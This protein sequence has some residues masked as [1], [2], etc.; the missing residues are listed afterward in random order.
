MAASRQATRFDPRSAAR[1]LLEALREGEPISALPEGAVPQTATQGWRVA[2]AVLAELDLPV[3]GFRAL[4]DGLAGPLL[5]PRLVAAGVQVPLAALPG[6]QASAACLVPLARALPPLSEPYS[7][8]RILAA[9]GPARAAIDLAAWRTSTRPTTAALR[10]ADLCGLGM[11]V[12][13]DPPRGAA[14]VDLGALRVSWNDDRAVVV[15]VTPQ[16]VA[17]AEAARLAGGLPAGA[18][19]V[20]TGLTPTH[21]P[22]SGTVLSVRVV[23][24]GK[25]SVTL[26]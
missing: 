10:I 8:R 12:V 2:R 15:D 3:V 4:A 20:A 16:L 6:L 23:G 9:L 17:A 26:V 25:A 19:L 7:L 5:A 18:A 11:L 13:A 1:A 21:A 14:S 24:A 22:P